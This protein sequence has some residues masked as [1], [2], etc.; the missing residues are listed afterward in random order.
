MRVTALLAWLFLLATPAWAQLQ[1]A[2]VEGIL[3]GAQGTP[4]VGALVQLDDAL[5]AT[6]RSQQTDS[7]GRFTF[8]D[9]AP[10]RY[11]LRAIVG[12]AEPLL[13]PLSISG[14]LP[15][16]VTLRFP[17]RF[18]GTVVVEAPLTSN[19]VSSRSSIA[20]A[21]IDE[22]P[23]RVRT[24]GLQ[25]L[26]ASLPGWATEDNGLLHARGIDDGF[27]YVIDGVPV[28]ER[29]DQLLGVSP[30]L[31]SVESVN[32]ITG[33][34]PAEFGHKAGG[35]IDVRTRAATTDWT[36]AAEIE[37]GSQQSVGASLSTGGRLKRTTTI[38]LGG[39]GQRSD[40]FLD[41]VHPDN[42]HNAGRSISTFGQ[43]AH[44]G[45][46]NSLNAS[47]G[48]GAARFDVPNTEEQATAR[49]NQRQTVQQMF[50]SAS[51]QRPWTSGTVS[52][53]SGYLRRS[54]ARLEGSAQDVPLFA[55]ADR[56]LVRAG[57]V[58]SVT[59]DLAGHLLKIGAEAQ[60]LQL[61][62][63]FSFSITDRRLAV[64]AGFSD[65]V[66][67][68][69]RLRPFVFDDQATPSLFSL[70]AQDEWRA[71]SKVT[72]SAGLRFDRSTSLLTRQ[73]LSP[74]I[75]SAYRVGGQ[76]SI[77]GS[78]SRFFQPPQPENLLLSS[79]E[80]ARALSPFAGGANGGGAEV[81]PERQWAFELGVEQGLGRRVRFDA[82]YWHRAIEQ[83]ADPN[84]FAGTTII[85]PNAVAS[86]RARG[87][88]LRLEMPKQNGWSAYLNASIGRVIQ[89][90][91]IT[92]GLFLEDDVGD[93]GD[94]EEFVPDHD[95]RLVAGGGL[96]WTHSR[97]GLTLSLAGR[98][99]SGTPIQR[100]DEDEE[101]LAAR[102]GAERVD[103]NRDRVKPRTVVSAIGD[104]PL[105]RSGNRSLRLRLSVLN[106]FNEA[107]AY[108]FGNPFSGTHFGA[109]RTFS[110]S[111]R[112]NF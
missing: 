33:Y 76:T 102:P 67:A 4:A 27:L 2:R 46:N 84:V 42:L 19:A 93:I 14:A 29:L 30:D 97:S 49:Q 83:T 73:Q 103:F 92:G 106:L 61:E 22:L 74:R 82:A 78:V 57:A 12:D 24:Q 107:Y 108:N 68:F 9:V 70:F 51:W 72:V 8:V 1:L 39:A 60:R 41:P 77:R 44:P 21:S 85:F 79:S 105:W 11:T 53:V 7:A 110:V 5:G 56:T 10:G 111:V 91:P 38:F 90:G 87:I 52:Q 94:G 109:P 36:T 45:D 100:G 71:S 63:S 112:A 31:S 54:R 16:E 25:D 47:W 95:Q 58:G 32:V 50:A 43:L 96:S 88:D 66:M 98:H 81:E 89:R 101:E 75:G 65:A 20:G 34:V 17:P 23:V 104:A 99:E 64:E 3:L 48:L 55:S 18:T 35:V 40:R 80:T 13:F 59:T 69:T 26:V 6:M 28:Y 86:G 62:E 37:G 15:V